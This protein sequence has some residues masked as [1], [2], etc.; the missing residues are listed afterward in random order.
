[1]CW[2]SSGSLF[3]RLKELM[4]RLGHTTA[5]MAMRY[6]RAETDRDRALA[7]AM[8]EEAARAAY[9]VPSAETGKGSAV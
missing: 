4:R 5:D 6:Q 1:M 2:R 3:D 9:S 7:K 8:S